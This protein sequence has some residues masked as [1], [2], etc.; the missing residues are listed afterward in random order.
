MGKR[1]DKKVRVNQR[2]DKLKKDIEELFIS[3]EFEIFDEYKV[4]IENE[5]IKIIKKYNIFSWC[6]KEWYVNS[7][8]E[9]I[10]NTY[11]FDV[12]TVKGNWRVLKINI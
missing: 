10:S 6:G 8:V 3:L 5:L 1:K 4:M 2:F 12:R 9:P 7:T 11:T